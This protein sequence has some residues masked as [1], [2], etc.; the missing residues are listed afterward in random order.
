MARL[1]SMPTEVSKKPGWIAAGESVVLLVVLGFLFWTAFSIGFANL[2]TTRAARTGQLESTNSA[3]RLNPKDPDAHF[4]R[5]SALVNDDRAA[6]NGEAMQA[7]ALRP[8][9]YVLWL[10]LTQTRELTD[11]LSGA[12]EAATQAAQ[13]APFYSQPHWRLGNALVRAGR[14]EEGFRELR[15][16]ANAEPSLLPSIIDLAWH[17]SNE[18]VE[19]VTNAVQPS[20]VEARIALSNYFRSHERFAD[21]VRVIGDAGFGA[22]DYRRRLLEE[23]I[24]RKQFAEAYQL[25]L[26][27]HSADVDK[28][29]A[30]FNPGFEKAS[31]FNE[32]GFGWRAANSPRI[33]FTTD[34]STLA[35]GKASLKIEFN[36]ESEAGLTLLSQLVT[37]EPNGHYTLKFAS[38]SD[39]LVSG[40][41]PAMSVTDAAT[42]AVLGES[43][44]RQQTDGWVDYTIDFAA[45]D[46]SSFIEI[47][48]QRRPCT[49]SP[50]PI[51][52]TLWLDRFILQKQ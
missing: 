21:A 32:T 9:D 24:S 2:Y 7:V 29:A 10:G 8:G 3:I 31:N 4:T 16:A 46:K 11:D 40:G 43:V 14:F 38:R 26:P 49:T 17:L 19:F 42:G 15:L 5:A 39:K 37:V 6:A 41:L 34:N 28:A 27:A 20:T 48:L 44:L 13:L 25:W 23:L 47:R 50:C 1:F 18:D 52:G 33:S 35:E 30:I 36:G 22:N 12:I 51:F 45:T